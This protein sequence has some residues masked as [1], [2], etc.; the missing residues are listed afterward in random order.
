MVMRN[1]AMAVKDKGVIVTL[2]NPGPVDTD[3]MKA[4]RGR[5]PLRAPQLAAQEVA[6]VIS[7]TAAD[8][9]GSFFNFDGTELPW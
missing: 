8:K 6:T 9:S 5:M 3:M 4:A 7:K 2:V 1:V